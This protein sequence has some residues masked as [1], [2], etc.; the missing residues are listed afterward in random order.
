M[1]NCNKPSLHNTVKTKTWSNNHLVIVP[2]NNH[3]VIVPENCGLTVHYTV[4]TKTWSNIHLVIVPENRIL[5][6]VD[7]GTR[8]SER[9]IGQGK[10]G[11]DF[12]MQNK[13]H[14]IRGFLHAAFPLTKHQYMCQCL[15]PMFSIN[16]VQHSP[17]KKNDNLA[18]VYLPIPISNVVRKLRE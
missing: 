10:R 16:R 15:F 14:I 12:I 11:S 7:F 17:T 2:S 9:R 1:S 4:K 5:C 8:A 13:S 3:L 6:Y 18:P